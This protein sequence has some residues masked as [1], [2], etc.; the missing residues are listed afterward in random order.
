MSDTLC[1]CRE[2]AMDDE[3]QRCTRCDRP[4]QV[5]SGAEVLQRATAAG[6]RVH[7]R[8]DGSLAVLGRN[9]TG[10]IRGLVWRHEA[11]VIAVLAEKNRQAARAAL[12]EAMA[13]DPEEAPALRGRQKKTLLTGH[14]W[15]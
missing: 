12:D 15:R 8:D 11:A 7:L 4:V 5:L 3:Q 10:E 1:L 13:L 6:L 14:G 2:P 9:S